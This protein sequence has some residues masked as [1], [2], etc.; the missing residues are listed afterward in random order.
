M[1]EEK[2]KMSQFKKFSLS[3]ISH[4]Q[5]HDFVHQ[6]PFCFALGYIQVPLHFIVLHFPGKYAGGNPVCPRPTPD[7]QKGISAFLLKSPN[8][9]KENQEPMEEDTGAWSVIE[10]MKV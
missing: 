8:S 4:I 9:D 3:H 2:L 10:N 6:L 5:Q 7:W 1:V